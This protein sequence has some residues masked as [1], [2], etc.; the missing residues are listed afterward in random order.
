MTRAELSELALW[1]SACAAR[2]ISSFENR[3]PSD[4]RPRNA[5]IAAQRW[6]AGEIE[7]HEA[8]E[9]SRGADRAA[10]EASDAA[11]TAAAR[12]CAEAALVSWGSLHAAAVAA[13]ARVAVFEEEAVDP[14]AAAAAELEWQRSALSPSLRV[15]LDPPTTLGGGSSTRV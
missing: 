5:L 8:R 7:G 4:S 12:C 15:I 1:A 14:A 6:A 13:Y 9:H 11:A 2:V 10:R 3:Y